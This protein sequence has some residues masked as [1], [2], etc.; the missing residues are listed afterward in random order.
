LGNNAITVARLRDAHLPELSFF[1]DP[2]EK[3]SQARE[4]VVVKAWQPIA[5]RRILYKPFELKHGI[6]EHGLVSK[7]TK[8]S[9]DW[10]ESSES[11]QKGYNRTYYF[12]RNNSGDVLWVFLDHISGSYWLQGLVD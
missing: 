10:W 9:G 6:G 12:Y 4:R 5:V 11:A 2:I 1:W 7:L 8:M 3:P